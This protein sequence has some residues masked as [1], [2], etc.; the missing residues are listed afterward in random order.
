MFDITKYFK[1]TIDL[2]NSL[3][4]KIDEI[5]KHF[6]YQYYIKNGLEVPI[7]YK[8]KYFLNLAGIR[9]ELDP[10]VYIRDASTGTDI[11]ITVEN[12]NNN[13]WIKRE[14]NKYG[15]LFNSLCNSYHGMSVYI[16]GCIN[17][18]KLDDLK[19]TPNY[20]LLYFNKDLIADN[21]LY[22]ISEIE[23]FVSVY[24]NTYHNPNYMLDALYLPQLLFNLYQSLVMYILTK[25]LENIFSN[26]VDRFHIDNFLSSYKNIYEVMDVFDKPTELYV[27]GNIRRF[28]TNLGKN[29]ILEE[30]LYKIYDRNSYGIGGLSFNK[31]VPVLIEDAKNDYKRAYFEDKYNFRVSKANNSLYNMDGVELSLEEV[32]NLEHI[33][34]LVND[35]NLL[36]DSYNILTKQESFFLKGQGYDTKT[37]TFL[38]DKPERIST[39]SNNVVISSLSNML[40]Y[41]NK[42]DSFLYID[43][44]NPYNHKLYKLNASDIKNILLANVLNMYKL[45]GVITI[46][47]EGIY[48]V[49][50]DKDSILSKTWHKADNTN[51]YDFI[52]EN[53]DNTMLRSGMIKEYFTL[54]NGVERRMWYMISNLDDLMLKND[55]RIMSK[56]LFLTETMTVDVNEVNKYI[57]DNDLVPFTLD[58]N[59]TTMISLLEFITGLDLEPDKSVIDRFKKLIEFFNKTTSYTIQLLYDTEFKHTF[60]NN[61]TKTNLNLGYKPLMEVKAAEWYKYE[62]AEYI[63]RSYNMEADSLDIKDNQI[64]TVFN[65]SKSVRQQCYMLPDDI[66]K[67]VM[68]M[69]HSYRR[70]IP[71][72]T[73]RLS[74][75]RVNDGG[76]ET[77]TNT[78]S[79]NIVPNVKKEL[80]VSFIED[81]VMSTNILISDS[82]YNRFHDYGT[83][84]GYFTSVLDNNDMDIN[85]KVLDSVITSMSGSKVSIG[86]DR[87][88]EPLPVYARR[89][90]HDFISTPSSK[91]EHA[92][93]NMVMFLDKEVESLDVKYVNPL[94][95][96]SIH[97]DFISY[98]LTSSTHE[99]MRSLTQVI[100]G[101]YSTTILDNSDLSYFNKDIE[102]VQKIT[103][104]IDDVEYDDI[105]SISPSAVRYSYRSMFN[106]SSGFRTEYYK[107]TKFY[108]E[109][110]KQVDVSKLKYST[111]YADIMEL[112]SFRLDTSNPLVL[113]YRTNNDNKSVI[114]NDDGHIL[115]IDNVSDLDNRKHYESN[116]VSKTVGIDGNILDSTLQ[117]GK[118]YGNGVILTNTGIDTIEDDIGKYEDVN[119]DNDN[120]NKDSSIVAKEETIDIDILEGSS[121]NGKPYG[122]NITT[123]DTS[124]NTTDDDVV[125]EL[126]TKP[127]YRKYSDTEVETDIE[128][129]IVDLTFEIK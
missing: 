8:D 95:V 67:D 69:G 122:S 119:I 27:Y 107:D 79:V 43:Y 45:E 106:P 61:V 65:I 19:A 121:Q 123:T 52:T 99:Y 18:I 58:C 49:N 70:P 104:G 42:S 40:S 13:I 29:E 120:K 1:S 128:D 86:E 93:D 102:T 87:I 32:I 81:S 112:N 50:A 6:N 35:D 7:F 48:N 72:S 110:E 57:E 63:I 126:V 114:T 76:I 17:P 129:I 26:K 24:M 47:L 75:T 66:I 20:R 101:L 96:K 21:E 22:L 31:E 16:R 36:S 41:L 68:L 111:V 15:E 90:Y 94:S 37:K 34:E 118:P 91:T 25:R 113:K 116:V 89:S 71:Y 78:K 11:E 127:S 60:V 23:H 88:V 77:V 73:S 33:A 117:N 56:Y 3:T 108:I 51:I 125:V 84:N 62:Q 92:L 115:T 74:L 10:Q 9:G 55:V 30:M 85:N 97:D 64:N 4:I 124:V 105:S 100:T 5:S 82:P 46:E 44:I 12:L 54:I 80:S 28:K 109:D 14:L 59:L 38:L 39:H 2:V 98:D 83:R 103:Q 53:P